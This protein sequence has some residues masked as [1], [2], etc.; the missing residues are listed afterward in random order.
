MPVSPELLLAAQAGD[1]QALTQLLGQ[2]RPDIR[3][4]ARRLCHSSSALEDV[5]QEALIVVYRRVGAVRSPA[6]FAAWLMKI[7]G[8]LCM[9]PA[10][11]LMR[12][13]EELGD[14]EERGRL[15]HVSPLDLR[16]DLVAALESLPATHREVVLLRDFEE[17]TIGEISARI[18]LGREATKSRLRRARVLLRDYLTDGEDR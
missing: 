2:L 4:Y 7:V 8:R 5:V 15:A 12:G 1:N 9:L 11:M 14:V 18:G 10:L 13:V 16:L 17:M 6:A 3:R